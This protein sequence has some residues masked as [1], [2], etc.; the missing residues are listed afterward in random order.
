M[1]EVK[2]PVGNMLDLRSMLLNLFECNL[3]DAS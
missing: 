2:I 3:I 1:E